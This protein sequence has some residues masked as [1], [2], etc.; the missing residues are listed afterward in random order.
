MKVK[1]LLAQ[2][3]K[4]KTQANA[5]KLLDTLQRVFGNTEPVCNLYMYNIEACME[6]GKP[7]VSFELNHKISDHYITMIRPEI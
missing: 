7:F 1:S 4:C 6:D 2:A 3:A 5:D